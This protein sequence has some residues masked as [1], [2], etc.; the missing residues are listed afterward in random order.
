MTILL[1]KDHVV[2]PKRL[3]LETKYFKK[4]LKLTSYSGEGEEQF[5]TTTFL[6]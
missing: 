4:L 2:S 5:L 6:E 3:V 1:T